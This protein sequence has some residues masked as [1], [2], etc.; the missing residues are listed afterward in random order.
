MYL[1]TFDI[2][3]DKILI[4]SVP[5]GQNMDSV[6]VMHCADMH[7]GKK[8][9]SFDKS[10]NRLRMYE[11]E[12]SCLLAVECASDCNIVLLSG[13]IFDSSDV[14]EELCK[15]FIDVISSMPDVRF[16]YSCGNHD[17][18]INRITD[19]L[20]CNCPDNLYIFG[21]EAVECVT[22][23]SLKT[24]V[25][26]ISF[27]KPYAKD[28]LIK[29]LDMCDPAYINIMCIHGEL[30]DKS[31][32]NPVDMKFLEKLGFDYVALGHVHGFDGFHK[33]NNL[34]YAY[35][36]C[37]EPS[38]FDE[39]GEKGY[40]KGFIN[41]SE[42][43]LRF[44]VS[45]KRQYHNIS[46][47]ISNIYDYATLISEVAEKVDCGNDLWRINLCGENKIDSFLNMELIE[48]NIDAFHIELHN[49]SK[50]PIDV[51][52]EAEN[53]SLLGLCAKETLKLIDEEPNE[54]RKKL[55]ENAF[56]MLCR[57]FDKGE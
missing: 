29:D 2:Y 55:Y 16:F 44:V 18:Y 40:I 1:L 25:Y 33:M 38:G 30:T 19:Y 35:S 4:Y 46:I 42:A 31:V 6:S 57:L 14:S 8:N 27:S 49:F 41:K 20:V 10:K 9:S 36:G 52:G 28:A 56:S 54:E 43:N 17:P 22:I 45:C 15:K 39:C 26:G 32:Y 23:E 5:E 24:K 53:F 7:L 12:M 3:N 48:K 34:T 13:D 37:T 50:I 47:D 11:T 21:Y 51:K